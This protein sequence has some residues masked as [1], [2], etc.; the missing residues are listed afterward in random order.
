MKEQLPKGFR[1]YSRSDVGN[2]RQG[3][4][5]SVVDEDGFQQRPVVAIT[6]G[7]E[8]TVIW[9]RQLDGLEDA[10]QARATHCVLGD[11]ALYVLLQSDTD[12]HPA[13]SQTL[14]SVARLDLD[15]EMRRLM[16]VNVPG[17]EDRAYSAF[18]GT[19]PADV[20]WRNGRLVIRGEYFFLSA[21]RDRMA[22]VVEIDGG[23]NHG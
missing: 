15:G 11:E 23:G 18:V 13:T 19:V 5:G 8:R 2:D 20:A 21:P 3:V 22:F 1:P 17:T 9:A 10:Y 16:P 14:L 12:S 4:A 6:A 7:G